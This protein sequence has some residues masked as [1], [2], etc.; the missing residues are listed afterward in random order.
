MIRSMVELA[1]DTECDDLIDSINEVTIERNITALRVVEAG[2][3]N[4]RMRL[5]V[6]RNSVTHK[7]NVSGHEGYVTIGLYDDGSPGEMFVRMAK[8][9]S[10]VR[11]LMDSVALIT[12]LALQYGTPLSQICDKMTGTKFEPYDEKSTSLMDCIFGWMW[13]TFGGGDRGHDHEKVW[14]NTR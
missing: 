4:G 8:S 12:S 13:S 10:T 14:R 2:E 6:T 11:G 9:G 5:P 7:F 1:H 3:T